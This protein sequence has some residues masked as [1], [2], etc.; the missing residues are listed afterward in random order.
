[1]V[2]A[3]GNEGR[4]NEI[5]FP[6][7][8]PGVVKVLAAANDAGGSGLAGYSNLPNPTAIGNELVFLAP[9]GLSLTQ[10]PV[11]AAW[12]D[13][14]VQ[15]RGN[16]GTSMAA[17]HVSGL[18][19]LVKAGFKKL[20]VMKANGVTPH[21]LQDVNAWIVGSASAPLTFNVAP[22]GQPAGF[23]TYRRVRLP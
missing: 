15:Y 1:M 7:C 23:R 5:S 16:A 3:T 12:I 10:F 4:R 13:P 17:P 20:N 11:V 2:A 21:D 14:A 18:Y 19:A 6:A 22:A 9:G 8:V